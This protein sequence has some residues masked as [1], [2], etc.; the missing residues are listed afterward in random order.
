M[1]L[2]ERQWDT[3][4]SIVDN[5]WM[6]HR[7]LTAATTDAL[8]GWMADHPE[9]DGKAR[10]LDLGCGDLALMAPVLAALPL[11]SYVGVDLTERPHHAAPWRPSRR[12]VRLGRRVPRSWG[13]EWPAMPPG[14]A[15]AGPRST[16]T[17][18]RR[19]SPT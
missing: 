6:E 14:S 7:G 4:R 19:S 2:F 13:I 9:R 18:G 12:R 10:L 5:D 16:T 17:R 15:A 3:Y 1:E 8:R 11:G